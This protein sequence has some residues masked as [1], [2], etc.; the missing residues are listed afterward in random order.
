MLGKPDSHKKKSESGQLPFTITK[1]NSEWIKD[2]NVRS[3]ITKLL[4][5]GPDN[6]F[7]YDSKNEGNKSKKKKFKWN[8][9]KIKTFCTTKETI[10]KMEK[11]PTMWEKIF[12]NH[13]SEKEFM[14]KNVQKTLTSY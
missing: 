8:C 14:F 3:E 6:F 11:K 12:V 2:F 5:I 4:D 9:L 7:K 10:N 1:I 13:I